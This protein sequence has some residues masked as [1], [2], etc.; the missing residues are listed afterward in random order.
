MAKKNIQKIFLGIV[1]ILFSAA[2]VAAAF[3]LLETKPRFWAQ[4]PTDLRM[5]QSASAADVV[6]SSEVLPAAGANHSGKKEGFLWVDRK[7]SQL[8]V[9]LGKLNGITQGRQLIVYEGTNRI[10][11]VVVDA[12]FETVSYVH[13]VGKMMNLLEN[14]YYRVGTE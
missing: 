10:G 4:K 1:L 5:P 14:T 13:A 7:S 11:E 3:Y 2:G 6:S 8:V 12:V 9:T